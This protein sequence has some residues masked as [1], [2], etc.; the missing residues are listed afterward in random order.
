M[1]QGLDR[2]LQL[3][4]GVVVFKMDMIADDSK[5]K[6]GGQSRAVASKRRRHL[7]MSPHER[8]WGGNVGMLE[9]S[10]YRMV[11][12]SAALASV[13]SLIRVVS[14]QTQST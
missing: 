5:K 4:G 11:V 8:E 7:N 9:G 2:K 12:G 10:R 13:L 3:E 1:D 6:A 14:G